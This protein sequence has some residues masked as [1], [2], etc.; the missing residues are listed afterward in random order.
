MSI[1][2][3]IFRAIGFWRKSPQQQVESRETDARFIGIL[4]LDQSFFFVFLTKF[5]DVWRRR[6]NSLHLSDTHSHTFAIFF[7][8][9]MSR[10][11]CNGAVSIARYPR[12]CFV[13]VCT[14]LHFFMGIRCAYALAFLLYYFYNAVEKKRRGQ[15]WTIK[16]MF[17]HIQLHG[18]FY[19]ASCSRIG[20][21]F[22]N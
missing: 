14:L 17:P 21:F 6:G 19:L 5:C 8:L 12:R 13:R 15:N 10:N 3:S 18:V 16:K 4:K 11:I 7:F 22:L 2:Y 9:L 20:V 1:S